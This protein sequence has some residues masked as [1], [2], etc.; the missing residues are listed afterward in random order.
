MCRTSR[1][2]H[3]SFLYLANRHV[4]P[5]LA[6]HNPPSSFAPAGTVATNKNL[7]GIMGAVGLRFSAAAICRLG[8]STILVVVVAAAPVVA[9]AT[10]ADL[11]GEQLNQTLPDFTFNVDV[12][13][14][15]RTFPWLGFHMEGAGKYEQGKQYSVHFTKLP[16]FAP[17]PQHD[18]DLSML[19]PAMW[20]SRFT[21][22][23]TGE[24]DGNTLFDLRSLEDPTLTNATVTLGPQWCARKVHAV[25][26]DGSQIDMNVKYNSVDGFMVPASLTATINVPHASLS[27]NGVFKDYS[28]EGLDRAHVDGTNGRK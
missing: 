20:P 10:K 16:W 7:S 11:G 8:T 23:K 5:F 25:Y 17:R 27:A 28:F 19:E 22:Q 15:M 24:E 1:P 4:E 2:T 26:N 14:R 9:C 13:M 18:A 12:A 3:T 6:S 21:Y